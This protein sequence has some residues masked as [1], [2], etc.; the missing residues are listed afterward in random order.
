MQI[1]ESTHGVVVVLKPDGALRSAAEAELLESRLRALLQG[2]VSGLVLDCA[3]V[4]ALSSAAVRVL[5]RAARKLAGSGGLLQLVHPADRLRR[6]LEVSGFD[7]DFAVAPGLAEALAAAAGPAS[8]PA[9]RELAQALLRSMGAQ[10]GLPVPSEAQ[11][12]ALL[13]LRQAVTSALGRSGR[14]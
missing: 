14:P 2:G 11:R 9:G 7:K 5:L 10:P 4:S 1:A 8:A 3:E 6:T 13:S 12:Q